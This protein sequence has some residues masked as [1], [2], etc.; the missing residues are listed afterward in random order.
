MLADHLIRF[1]QTLRPPGNLPKGIEVLFPQQQKEVM[2]VI[3]IFFK[4]FYT[5]NYS[6][7]LI[8]G[9]NPGRFGAGTTG[10]NFTAPKQLKEYCGIDHPFKQQT[11]LSAEFIYEMIGRYGGVENFYRDYFIS[12]ISPLG[13]IRQGKNL[14]YYDDKKLEAAV[15]PFIVE[16]IRKQVSFGFETNYCICIGGEKNFKFFSA[17]NKEQHF[18]DEIIPLPHPRFIM[19]YRRKKK[20]NYIRQY[21]L[22]L[23]LP[24]K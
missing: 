10:I 8:F 20:E 22:A 6:R 2:H 18:F 19:Q 23:L 12:A 9:I 13:F 15:K 7:H 17:L 21:L 24:V 11:E 1:Y 5:D 14:N 4:K 16:S 3:K